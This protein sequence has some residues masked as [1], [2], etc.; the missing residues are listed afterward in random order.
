[1]KRILCILWLAC[2][3]LLDTHAQTDE[4]ADKYNEFRQEASQRYADFRA[5]VNKQYADFV[6]K[7]WKQHKVLPA[8]PHPHEKDIQPVIYE[9]KEKKNKEKKTKKDRKPWPKDDEKEFEEN[10][11][12]EYK[13]KI[14][15]KRDKNKQPIINDDKGKEGDDEKEI[16]VEE[17]IAP[18]PPAPQPKPIS[19]IREQ[20]EEGEGMS[21][22]FFGAK[23]R[24]RLHP[25]QAIRLEGID[26]K[27]VAVGWDL[28]STSNLDNA[29]RDC[30]EL[31]MRHNLC[32][33]GY[34]LLL[35]EVAQEFCGKNTN[36][37]TL[38]LA[39]LY[40]QSGYKM[41]LASDCGKLVMLYASEHLIYNTSYY[42]INGDFF[43]PFNFEP[44]S[45][46]ISEATFPSEKPLSLW[47]DKEQKLGNTM[48]K[49]RILRS[50]GYPDMSVRICEN[51]DLMSFYE[52][53]PSSQIGDN[54]VSRWAIYANAPL[55]ERTRKMLY[56]ALRQ[57]MEGKSNLQKVSLLLDW[58]QT[59]FVY[60]YDDKV[61]GRDR[62]FFADETLY[63]PYSDCEDRSI[64]F[65]RLVRDLVG[66][67]VAL[68]YYPGHLAAAVQFEE[69]VS[70]DYLLINNRRYTITDPTYIGAPVG[71]TMPGMDNL[72]AKVIVLP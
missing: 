26:E 40:C 32:D 34:L 30:L 37:A 20:R 51:E 64:L 25:R 54:N 24:V 4:F 43:Y 58:V 5:K 8:I 7:V 63:Y 9:D 21:F 49:E 59:A 48:S 31:R 22:T 29:I 13:D 16:A 55:C 23:C 33:W 53:Y 62:A 50:K 66:L 52:T 65:S 57:F 36:E 42:N 39:F 56:P 14:P 69:E 19:P 11:K 41:R 17:V 72:K 18:P 10:D 44:R 6:K 1:M 2:L 28:L 71:D 46:H 27:S 3:F 70:G 67:N 60:E 68:V 15:V 35:H 12:N 47:I 61:W 38:L 45:T